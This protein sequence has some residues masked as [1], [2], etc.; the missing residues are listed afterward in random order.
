MWNG[1]SP[2]CMPLSQAVRKAMRV[3]SVMNHLI[4][5][6]PRKIYFLENGRRRKTE[7]MQLWMEKVLQMKRLMSE[8]PPSPKSPNHSNFLP[9]AKKRK[10]KAK[11]KKSKVN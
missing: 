10:R 5:N 3:T 2:D 11:K 9:K 8:V 1:N 4:V 6:S 7:A